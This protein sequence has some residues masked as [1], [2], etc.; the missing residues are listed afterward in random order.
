[1]INADKGTLNVKIQAKRY[2]VYYI[3]F[4]AIFISFY[5]ITYYNCLI[6][7]DK[8]TDTA[9]AICR[10]KM[11]HLSKERMGDYYTSTLAQWYAKDI[12]FPE[13]VG[14]YRFW[15]N[16]NIVVPIF[17]LVTIAL[18]PLIM[19]TKIGMRWVW[20]KE[21]V[22]AVPLFTILLGIN[23]HAF[24]MLAD[25]GFGNTPFQYIATIVEAVGVLTF[26]PITAVW[27][28]FLP[29]NIKRYRYELLHGDEKCKKCSYNLTAN[30][31]GVCPECGTRINP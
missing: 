21:I 2:Q 28:I 5:V 27:L 13:N 20:W 16:N 31:S 17:P 15:G 29:S 22:P 25:A 24:R 23:G 12:I 9:T 4:L 14:W 26:I 19:F 3:L 6:W 11:A 10:G 7:Y 8:N 30:E 1:M 18:L